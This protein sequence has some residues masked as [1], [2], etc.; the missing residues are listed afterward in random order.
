MTE[1]NPPESIRDGTARTESIGNIRIFIEALERLGYDGDELLQ[2]IQLRRSDFN[3]PDGRVPCSLVGAMFG[4]AMQERPLK[5]LGTRI[6]AETPIG[7]FPLIDYLVLTSESVGQGL[8]KLSQYFRLVDFPVLIDIHEEESTVQIVYNGS[9][10]PFGCEFGVALSIL[11]LREE[12]G[13]EF[14]AEHVNFV[15]SPEDVAEIERL[16]AC[17]VRTGRPW[18]GWV[19]SRDVW[20]L[21]LRRRDPI[22][23][24]LLETQAKDMLHRLPAS[25]GTAIRVRRVLISRVAGGDTDIEAVA[26]TLATSARSLQRQLTAE[27]ISYRELLEATRKEAAERYLS[28]SSL[29]ITEIAYLLGYSE[30]AAFHRAFKRWYDT[31]PLAFRQRYPSQGRYA[32]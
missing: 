1:G 21:S 32:T 12:T 8:R 15:H 3:D 5:N 17:P 7:A 18:T 10:S 9:P 13:N 6:A 23:S 24:G 22:L 25:V 2:A 27:G 4:R 20:T 29:S 31:T 16:L 30:V 11:H 14:H 28:N 19:M 26:R